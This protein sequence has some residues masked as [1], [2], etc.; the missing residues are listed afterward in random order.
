VYLVVQMV[1]DRQQETIAAM[2]KSWPFV[3]VTMDMMAMV[4]AKAD[5]STMQLYEGKL[6]DKS[7]HHVGEELRKSFRKTREAV[8]SIVGAGSVLGSGARQAWFRRFSTSV[9]LLVLQPYTLPFLSRAWHIS[10]SPHPHQ[11]P[12]LLGIQCRLCLPSLPWPCY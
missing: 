4:L 5:D 10:A 11:R 2:Y 12:H 8:L 9:K 3:K 6:V 7:L 1:V